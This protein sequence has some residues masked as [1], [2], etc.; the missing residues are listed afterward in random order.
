MKKL[1][2]LTL[3]LIM[4]LSLAACGGETNTTVEASN[5]LETSNVVE[6]SSTVEP[7]ALV[8]VTSDLGISIKLPGDL[9]LQEN[10]SYLNTETGDNVVFGASEI[11]GT[12]L[13]GWKEENILAT[14]QSKYEGV[15][16]NSFENSKQIDGK[17]SLVASVALKTPKGN[18]ITVVLVML[19]DGVQNYIVN[20]TYGSGNADS[21]LAK[22]LQACI[23]SITIK[24]AEGN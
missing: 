3:V 15:V 11:G 24:T 2:L 7:E 4:T 14:Y 21:S 9:K 16:V 8:E 6:A 17:E 18:D 20:F 13:S 5:V 10:L 1:F 12:P 23:D 19:T 22:N